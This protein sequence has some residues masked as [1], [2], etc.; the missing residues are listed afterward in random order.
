MTF[1]VAAHLDQHTYATFAGGAIIVG[2]T[3]IS[4][5]TAVSL[6]CCCYLFSRAVRRRIA[7]TK[8]CKKVQNARTKMQFDLRAEQLNGIAVS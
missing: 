2:E 1:S 5:N 6:V 3:I 8:T 7:L 4:P